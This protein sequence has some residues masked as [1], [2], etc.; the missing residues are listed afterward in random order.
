[1][2]GKIFKFF[3]FVIF[4]N[5]IY[6]FLEFLK[7]FGNWFL[8]ITLNSFHEVNDFVFVL[9]ISFQSMYFADLSFYLF[10]LHL[11]F[12]FLNIFFRGKP[13]T[14]LGSD[15]FVRILSLSQVMFIHTDNAVWFLPFLP[16]NVPKIYLMKF[17]IT[18]FCVYSIES[19]VLKFCAF[20]S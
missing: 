18:N 1:M 5:F 20:L 9:N 6:L 19:F 2:W 17:Y 11:V 8:L 4:A 10:E 7:C 15:S 13:L 12:Y 14:W 3:I 16:W